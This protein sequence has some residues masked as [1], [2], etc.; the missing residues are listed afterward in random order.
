MLN[1][2]RH[3]P[4]CPHNCA[5]S[6]HTKRYLYGVQNISSKYNDIPVKLE[7]TVHIFFCVHEQDIGSKSTLFQYVL[8][9]MLS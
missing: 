5:L 4:A 8:H 9:L 7:A 3:L 2:F 6:Q 1:K